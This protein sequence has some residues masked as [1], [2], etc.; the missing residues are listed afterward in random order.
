MG[1]STPSDA[2]VPVV[3]IEAARPESADTALGRSASAMTGAITPKRRNRLSM[4]RYLTYVEAGTVQMLRRRPSQ[5]QSHRGFKT[6]L[7][8]RRLR[9]YGLRLHTLG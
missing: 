7:K 6:G 9:L 2:R 3:P 8:R 5:S 4:V 1:T